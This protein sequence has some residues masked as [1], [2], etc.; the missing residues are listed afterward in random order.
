M[1]N[2]YYCIVS[3]FNLSIFSQLFHKEKIYCSVTV[4]LHMRFSKIKQKK[5]IAFEI[6]IILL[7]YLQFKLL[8]L[9]NISN[10]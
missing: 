8:V 9:F 6:E 1:I 4:M 5:K 10:S 3:I 2:Y 7:Y